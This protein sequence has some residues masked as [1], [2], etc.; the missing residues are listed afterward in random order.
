MKYFDAHTHTQ[1]AAFDADRDKVMHRAEEAGVGMNIVGTQYDTSKS[2]VEMAE[3]FPDT[4]ASVALHPIH[5]ARSH[6]DEGE[7]FDPTLYEALAQSKKVIA[8]GECGLDYYRNDES[9]KGLQQKVFVE[10][11]ELS[12]RV[13]KPLMLHVRDQK[14]SFDAYHDVLALLRQ[15]PHVPGDVHFFA[16]DW[17]TA[18]QFLDLGFTLSFTGVISFTHD[19]DEVVRQTPLDMLLCETDAPY[20]TP[21]PYRGA[22]NEPLYVREVVAAL[23]HIRGEDENLVREQLMQNARRVF[24]IRV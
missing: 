18:K 2:A 13:G 1:F 22:R 10:H 16:G 4:Y 3:R 8:I 21:A 19:Y 7:I 11:I 24:N 15:H 6:N 9:T 20:V 23:A 12:Q 5:T 17:V 14:G